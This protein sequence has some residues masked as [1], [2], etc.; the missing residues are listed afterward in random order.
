MNGKSYVYVARF[1]PISQQYASLDLV[2]SLP[3]D[4]VAVNGIYEQAFA[5]FKPARSAVEVAR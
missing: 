1:G 5:P 3:A 4:F 2:F